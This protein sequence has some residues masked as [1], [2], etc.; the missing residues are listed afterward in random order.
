MKEEK[1]ERYQKKFHQKPINAY[2]FLLLRKRRGWMKKK[3]S[4]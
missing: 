4:V 3:E 2:K 1:G